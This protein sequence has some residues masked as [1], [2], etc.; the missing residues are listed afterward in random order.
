MKVAPATR[1]IPSLM[2][3]RTGGGAEGGLWAAE[4][5]GVLIV[6]DGANTLTASAPGGHDPQSEA[7]QAALD[8]ALATGDATALT[9]LPDGPVGRV[10]YQV[11]A[12]LAPHPD[13]AVA[14]AAGAPYGVGYF[15]G[16]WNPGP[17]R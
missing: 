7:V 14:L 9:R 16:T 15:V 17:P 13:G 4:A 6:A 11:L 1:T 2:G 12:G 10:A 8:H 3:T 5:V